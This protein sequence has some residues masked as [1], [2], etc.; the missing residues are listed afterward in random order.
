MGIIVS[1][2]QMA[3]S[4]LHRNASHPSEVRER[5][6]CLSNQ[7]SCSGN[8]CLHTIVLSG[9]QRTREN[10]VKKGPLLNVTLEL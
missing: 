1:Q 8:I 5:L 4:N 7:N 3:V 9:I 2:C 10:E 6:L